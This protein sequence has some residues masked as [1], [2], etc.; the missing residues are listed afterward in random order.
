MEPIEKRMATAK[1]IS[2]KEEVCVEA[3]ENNQQNVIDLLNDKSKLAYNEIESYYVS[4]SNGYDKRAVQCQYVGFTVES[5]KEDVIKNREFG[6]NGLLKLIS[7]LLDK[8]VVL[9]FL[10]P[11]MVME[12]AMVSGKPDQIRNLY[13]FYP[14]IKYEFIRSENHE[15]NRIALQDL[16]KQNHETHFMSVNREGELPTSTWV[17]N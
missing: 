15:E 7:F 6:I 9:K 4:E 3:E 17:I 14:I 8:D 12:L 5:S 2:L 1:I 16:I 10:A 13:L 11:P